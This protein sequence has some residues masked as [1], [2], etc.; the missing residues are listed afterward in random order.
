MISLYFASA[1]LVHTL[2]MIAS[3]SPSSLA[4]HS[5]ITSPYDQVCQAHS[6]VFQDILEYDNSTKKLSKNSLNFSNLSYNS[7]HELKPDSAYPIQSERYGFHRDSCYPHPTDQKQEPVCIYLNPNFD[8]GQGIV[9][10]TRIPVFEEGLEQFTSFRSTSGSKRHNR[11]ELPFKVIDMAHKGGKGAISNRKLHLGDSVITSHPVVVMAAEPES[12]NRSDWVKIR[13]RGINLLPSRTRDEIFKLHG[14]GENEEDLAGSILERNSFETRFGNQSNLH[15]ALVLTPSVAFYFDDHALQVSMHAIRDISPGEELTI[16]YRDMKLPRLERQQE[17][18]DYGFNCTCSLCSLPDLPARLS[19]DRIYEMGELD[20]ILQ[21]WSIHSSATPATS[22]RLITL[23]KLVSLS[24]RSFWFS[25]LYHFDSNFLLVWF[26]LDKERMDNG[27]EEGYTL[28][29]LSYNSVG[30]VERA[31]M[32]ASLALAYGTVSS[33]P[34][35]ED[36]DSVLQLEQEP[37]Q[38]WSYKK[39]L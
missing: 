26:S 14:V 18:E 15:F 34:K 2:F 17:L 39:R 7:D 37:E 25:T 28:A 22:E 12:L 11:H 29:S 35:W 9:F 19:D 31:K 27:I 8:Q 13:K 36:F 30:D 20:G 1:M 21:D 38:H 10:I 3:H 5:D 33:G 16:S 4:F 23:F 6:T 32:Y 24:T